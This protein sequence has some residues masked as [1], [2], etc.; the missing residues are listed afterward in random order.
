MP[1][2]WTVTDELAFHKAMVTLAKTRQNPRPDENYRR[3]IRNPLSQSSA[4]V[5]RLEDELQ[6][7]DHLAFLAHN[8]EGFPA[9]TSICIE[10]HPGKQGLTVRL[11]R[12]E[13]RDDLATGDIRKVLHLLQRCATQGKCKAVFLNPH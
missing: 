10:E 12:N 13:L 5:L 8:C 1:S 9:I 11:V 2:L 4:H 6:L 7:A 3:S